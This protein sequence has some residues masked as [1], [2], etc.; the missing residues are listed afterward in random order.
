MRGFVRSAIR[1]I[2]HPAGGIPPFE[3]HDHLQAL[4]LDVLLHDHELALKAPQ[5]LVELL[6]R[7]LLRPA[8]AVR[9]GAVR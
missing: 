7:Q 1:L 9:S 8:L 3:D 4:G 2:T 5:L 6:A